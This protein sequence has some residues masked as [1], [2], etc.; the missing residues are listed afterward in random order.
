MSAAIDHVLDRLIRLAEQALPKG[1]TP[2]CDAASLAFALRDQLPWLQALRADVRQV[3]AANSQLRES[4]FAL[5]REYLQLKREL[6]QLI[7]KQ[8]SL[9]REMEQVQATAQ[10]IA[11]EA[12]A[13]L[14][15]ELGFEGSR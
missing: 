15:T 3:R 2:T 10:A 11:A 12:H 4:N 1:C 8:A 14:Q 5:E 9:C 6:A 13:R 7:D